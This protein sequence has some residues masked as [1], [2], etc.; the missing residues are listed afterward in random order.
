MYISFATAFVARPTHPLALHVLA[1]LGHARNS[2]LVVLPIDEDGAGQKH[3][4]SQRAV[5]RTLEAG[6]MQLSLVAAPTH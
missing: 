5:Q 2:R 4:E 6:D 3:W 1:G